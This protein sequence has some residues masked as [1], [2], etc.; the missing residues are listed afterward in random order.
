[1][2]SDSLS[3]NRASTSML[4]RLLTL[5][6]I[7][8]VGIGALVLGVGELREARASLSWP[9]VPAV[10][11]RSDAGAREGCITFSYRVA[12]QAYTATTVLLREEEIK[13]GE[14]RP[15]CREGVVRRYPAGMAVV[16][17]YDPKKPAYAILEP[18]PNIGTYFLPAV[19]VVFTLVGSLFLLN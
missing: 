14:R 8:V 17:W 10:I 4:A 9:S 12:G 6:V 7:L 1:N 5:L 15:S 3:V 2:H 13:I 11:E 19:G 16:A 18:G